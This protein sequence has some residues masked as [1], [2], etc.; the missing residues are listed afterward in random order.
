MT[1]QER[2]NKKIA[3]AQA[4]AQKLVE[5]EAKTI[6]SKI[7]KAIEKAERAASNIVKKEEKIAIEMEKLEELKMKLEDSE[8]A[9]AELR[10]TKLEIT[11]GSILIS[12]T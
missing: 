11:V 9:V 5:A 6:D 12:T 2:V 8:Q 1:L 4:A 10:A 7:V 3:D